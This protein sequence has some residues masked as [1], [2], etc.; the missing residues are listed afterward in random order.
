MKTVRLGRTGLMVSRVGMGGIPITRTPLEDVPKVVG[1]ALDLGVNLIDTAVGYSTSEER[2]GIGVAGRRDEVFLAT[3]TPARD[4]R[5]ARDHLEISLKRFGTDHIDIWQF[6]GVSSEDWKKIL[7]PG[8]AMEA[9]K[10]ALRAGKVGHIGASSHNF[11]AA[12][13]LIASG[14]IETIQFPFNFVTP[15]AERLVKLAEEHD[16]GFIA[17]KPF[18]GRVLTD[19][20][21]LAIRY[22]LQFDN[23]IPIPGVEKAEEIEEIVGLAEAPK[24]ITKAERKLMAEIKEGLGSR[25]C[26]QCEYC[27]PCPQGV[28]IPGILYL[29]RLYELWPQERFFSWK[30]VSDSVASAEG[31]V[32]CG[33]CEERCL[34]RLPIREM[35][36]EN[37]EFYNGVAKG[38]AE[39]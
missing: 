16:V 22:L 5:T 31:C 8:G 35:I 24:P 14:A 26:R 17:M 25:Y 20:V 34:F 19:N 28:F 37:I 33:A 23:V 10:E 6:H 38:R 27:L 29:K 3:K 39:Q 21:G 11:E 2:I 30:Y 32:K 9:A 12:E 15:E 7:G 13:M 18:A 1:R 36:D 4:A